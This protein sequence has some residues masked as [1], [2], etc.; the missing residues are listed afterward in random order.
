MANG[1]W[2]LTVPS[3]AN[4]TIQLHVEN[5]DLTMGRAMP[6]QKAQ[7]I[8]RPGTVVVH[9]DR[10]GME[11]T[12]TA[13]VWGDTEYDDLQTVI[14]YE[15]PVVVSSPTGLSWTVAIGDVTETWLATGSYATAPARALSLA[16]T[17]VA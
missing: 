11:M 9:G 8:G 10:A 15:E 7:V 14:G 6:Q 3:R 17:E 16:L 4:H 13:R 1:R 2:T 5:G 12:L